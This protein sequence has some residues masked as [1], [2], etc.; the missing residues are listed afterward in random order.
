MTTTK[1]K[2]SSILGKKKSITIRKPI[3]NKI[4]LKKQ[5]EGISPNITHSFDASNVSLLIKRLIDID[6]YINLLTIHDCFA[7]SPNNVELM[8]LHVKLAFLMLYA[9]KNFIT[10]YH[11]F[12]LEYVKNNLE[13]IDNNVILIN[14]KNKK[15]KS[16]PI[17]NIPKFEVN[18]EF[19][20]NLLGSQYFLN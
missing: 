20:A 7:T 16:I 10:N 13:I 18:P 1:E 11:N 5:N 12:I 15:S 17:P 6:Q 19:K 3:E 14:N 8:F 4:N 9:D 2:S